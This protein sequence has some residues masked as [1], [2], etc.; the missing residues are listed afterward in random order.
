LI[1][2]NTVF[3]MSSM[4]LALA[5]PT[6]LLD[7]LHAPRWLSSSILVA[8]TVVLSV[9]AAPVVRRLAPYRRTRAIIAAAGCWA[10]WSFLLALLRPAGLEVLL[11]VLI[12]ATAFFTLAELLHAPVAMALASALSPAQARGRYLAA[13]Q[14][15]FTIAGLISPV[16]FTTLF[17]LN[18][19]APWIALGLVNLIALLATRRLEQL[20]PAAAQYDQPPAVAAA[21]A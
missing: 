16:F 18:R 20:I 2:I 9:L 14:Y 1:G 11:P 10:L 12:V 8:N 6:F 4:M 5:L 19:A 3:A 21:P 7:G 13:F 15:T 17:E